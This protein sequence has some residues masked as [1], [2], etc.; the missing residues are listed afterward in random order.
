MNDD[1]EQRLHA[2]RLAR[3]SAE[4]DRRM[5]ELFAATEAPLPRKVG[6]WFVLTAPLAGVAAALTVF[7]IQAQRPASV[8]TPIIWQIEPKGLM[9]EMLVPAARAPLPVFEAVVRLGEASP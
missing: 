1:L 5:D 7:T 3:P 4:L 9:R 6:W 8:P 2:L